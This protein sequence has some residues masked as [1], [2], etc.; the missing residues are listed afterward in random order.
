MTAVKETGEPAGKRSLSFFAPS[1]I[2]FAVGLLTYVLVMK[3]VIHASHNV[4]IFTTVGLSIVLVAMATPWLW[5]S[6]RR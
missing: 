1:A 6:R 3:G 5:L 4:Q 2:F